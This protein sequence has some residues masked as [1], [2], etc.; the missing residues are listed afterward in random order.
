[1]PGTQGAE[2]VELLFQKL[3]ALPREIDLSIVQ[4]SIRV[5][6]RFAE[7]LANKSSQP[8]PRALRGRTRRQRLATTVVYC[9]AIKPDTET[10]ARPAYL[11]SESFVTMFPFG[12]QF[13]IDPARRATGSG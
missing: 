12:R 4:T 13:G 1:M 9:S 10:N 2:P 7:I 8:E 11:D 3:R 6:F 5:V